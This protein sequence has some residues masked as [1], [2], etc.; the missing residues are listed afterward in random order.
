MWVVP[1]VNA[2]AT[3]AV[4]QVDRHRCALPLSESQL[5]MRS[6]V[7][8][9]AYFT[10][11]P[12]EAVLTCDEQCVRDRSLMLERSRERSRDHRRA[13]AVTVRL[14]RSGNSRNRETPK[15][16]ATT[17]PVV[18]YSDHDVERRTDED[19]TPR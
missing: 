6:F 4:H 14:I 16:D 12:H 8:F 1:S 18:E 3:S 11:G 10:G 19:P 5:R 2:P 9:T 15:R 13:C 7:I 17:R